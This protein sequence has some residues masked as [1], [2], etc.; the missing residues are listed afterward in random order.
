VESTLIPYLKGKELEELVLW[1]TRTA[2]DPAGL[3]TLGRYGVM[4]NFIKGTWTP[5]KSLP[6]FEGVLPG[7]RQFIFEAKVC[8][9]ASYDLT[10][11]TSKSFAHQ[12]AHLRKRASWG[13]L[14]F[15][16]LHFNPRQLKKEA[17][18]G[19]TVLFPVGDTEFWQAYDARQQK[20]ITRKAA[21]MYGIVVPWNIAP[22]K[23]TIAPDLGAALLEYSAE[24]TTKG[25]THD[26]N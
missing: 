25:D 23:R 16:L 12:Y 1:R 17:V 7:G 4:S 13:A 22:G 21:E 6:D 3:Y 2:D 19:C 11:G 26:N 24:K 18:P 9:Q 8:S 14:C 5:V 10:G 15:I 20:N